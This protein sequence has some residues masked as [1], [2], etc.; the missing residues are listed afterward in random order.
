[1][2]RF[3][4][5]D[6]A[7]ELIYLAHCVPNPPDKGEKIRAFHELQF[8][9]AH[10]RVHLVCFARSENDVARAM[11]LRQCASIYVERLSKRTALARAAVAICGGWLPNHLV[12]F[13]P[14]NDA[15]RAPS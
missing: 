5:G 6:S 2:T 9:V 15:A 14:L 3:R 11:E 7:P 10:Y 12:L 13:Q 8:L 4:G 1:V